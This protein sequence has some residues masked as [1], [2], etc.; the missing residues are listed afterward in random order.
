MKPLVFLLF[1]QPSSWLR[2][3]WQQQV[4]A[5]RWGPERARS[6][7]KSTD[8]LWVLAP[9]PVD[10]CAE[11]CRCAHDGSISSSSSSFIYRRECSNVGRTEGGEKYKAGWTFLQMKQVGLSSPTARRLLLATLGQL[12]QWKP[13]TLSHCG[14]GSASIHIQRGRGHLSQ[15]K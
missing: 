14:K 12:F 4:Q 6:H 8:A 13:C 1:F 10:T 3:W 2:W 15:K 9:S 11:G 5:T 7:I